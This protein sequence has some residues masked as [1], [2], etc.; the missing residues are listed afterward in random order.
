MRFIIRPN[1]ILGT[2]RALKDAFNARL[3]TNSRFIT[4]RLDSASRVHRP[5]EYRG[6]DFFLAYPGHSLVRTDASVSGELYDIARQFFLATKR[7]QRGAICHAG[8]PIPKTYTALCEQRSVG[9]AGE[10]HV[11]LELQL[12]DVSGSEETIQP[13][14][15]SDADRA[16]KFVVRP[17]R[18][19]GGT[20]YRITTDPTAWDPERE[21]LSELYPKDREY[22][23]VCVRGE[24]LFTLLK[25]TPEG[26]SNTEPWNHTNGSYFVTV[27]DWS[28]NRLRH[29]DIF[30]RI[31]SSD[32]IRSFDLCGID[33]LWSR[34]HEQPYVVCEVNLCPA[35]SIE[36]NL[37]KVV[38]HVVSH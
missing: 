33:V 23:I 30:D 14:S 34:E 15:V 18:H 11:Q 3:E 37:R 27:Q 1:H 21:Y 26:L 24:P 2:P 32:L 19:Y 4:R 36:S 22:R 10:G 5:L 31:R 20:E 9:G 25:R 8:F 6:R 28:K 38:D 7:D 16:R 29:T 13:S 35:L 17:L 12:L